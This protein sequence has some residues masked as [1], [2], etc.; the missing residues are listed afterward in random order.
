[1]ETSSRT[2]QRERWDMVEQFIIRGSIG[3]IT[4]GFISSANY[5]EQFITQE[6]S[7]ISLLSLSETKAQQV[8][9]FI[10]TAG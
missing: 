10:M 4:G 6:Q 8:E 9:Q 7:K 1:M 3:N 5:V 2:Q